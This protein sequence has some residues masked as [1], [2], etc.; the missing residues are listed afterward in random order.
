MR[1]RTRLDA[2]VSNYNRLQ[3]QLNEQ[4]DLIKLAEDEND[5]DVIGD[6]EA[7]IK[8]LASQTARLRLESLLSGEA[9]SNSAFLE[10][11]AG[12]GGTESQ[13]WAAM[14]V[15]MYVRWADS[16]QYSVEWIE[17]RVLEKRP[18]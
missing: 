15:R 12:A 6:A 13:D 18:D 16:H 14:L 11:H 1:E 2:I 4:V 9:D 10:I 8:T 3:N 5:T 7:V 17:E